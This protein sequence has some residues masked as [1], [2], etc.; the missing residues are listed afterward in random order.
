[1]GFVGILGL[2]KA[3]GGGGGGRLRL[4]SPKMSETLLQRISTYGTHGHSTPTVL[5]QSSTIQA[6]SIIDP[7]D[8]HGQKQGFTK[9]LRQAHNRFHGR[10]ARK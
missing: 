1:M 7:V 2:F 3:F 5:Q 9:S 10:G 4:D 8:K 6:R